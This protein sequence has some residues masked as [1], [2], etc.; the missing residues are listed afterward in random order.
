MTWTLTWIQLA[1]APQPLSHSLLI[2]MRK[3]MKK[4]IIFLIPSP[5]HEHIS[6]AFFNIPFPLLL[7]SSRAII[8]E[9]WNPW[10]YSR[11]CVGDERNVEG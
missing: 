4:N 10:T 1:G 9:S 5:T 8:Q 3:D 7:L 2:R 6:L 11:N